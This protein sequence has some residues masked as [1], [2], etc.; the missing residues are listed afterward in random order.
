[1]T[2]QWIR[3]K[4]DG[5]IYPY[6]EILARNPECEVVSEQVAFPEKFITPEVQAAIERHAP[7][8]AEAQPVAAPR[9]RTRQRKAPLDLS[10][11][12]AGD[13]PVYTPPELAQDAAKGFP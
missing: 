7:P 8:P 11:P 2:T 13:P 4:K 3:V 6:D 1:V 5:F 9:P 10:T 12:A